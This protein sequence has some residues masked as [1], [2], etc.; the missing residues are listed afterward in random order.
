MVVA[1]EDEDNT[2]CAP[3]SSTAIATPEQEQTPSK[4]VAL[5]DCVNSN[6]GAAADE[7]LVSVEL[8]IKNLEAQLAAA[9]SV[10]RQSE[11]LR[12][13]WA[14][15]KNV[16]QLEDAGVVEFAMILDQDPVEMA[17]VPDD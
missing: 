2:D 9:L 4:S 10:I 8:R 1:N 6:T 17:E 15:R 12:A 5:Q 14:S 7:R 3:A 13:E 16:L 11:V